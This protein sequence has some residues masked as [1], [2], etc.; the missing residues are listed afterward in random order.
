MF[1]MIEKQ[2]KEYRI[3]DG[4]IN[5]L[6]HV[7]NKIETLEASAEENRAIEEELRKRGAIYFK[8]IELLPHRIVFK[9]VNLSYVFCNEAY[10]IDFNIGPDGI[11]GKSD[12]DFLSADLA[13]RSIAE[14]SEILRSGAGQEIEE[15]YAVSGREL[16]VL[17][18]KTPVRSDDGDIMGLLVV[19]RD[20]TEDKRR[21][22]NHASRLKDLEDLIA[23]EKEVNESLRA[24]L[25]SMTARRDQL[26]NEFK[27]MQ[28]SMNERIALLEAE[29]EKL[30]NDLE[31]E[32]AERK[33]AVELLRNSFMRIQDLMNSVQH[34]M[35]PPGGMT[36]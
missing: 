36:S 20:I 6:T 3:I 28:Q 34:L 22:E 15:T 12:R 16:T 14:E 32:T 7:L 31:R 9:D 2:G 10:A 24:D 23:R 18:T 26:E 33:D 5:E 19:L 1:M 30:T 25:G 4:M 29:R 8:V 27:G 17:A 21:E 35:K 13:E 11:E